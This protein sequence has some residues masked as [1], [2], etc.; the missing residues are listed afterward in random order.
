MF[1]RKKRRGSENDS[2]LGGSKKRSNNKKSSDPTEVHRMQRN[3]QG[4]IS[5]PPIPIDTLSRHV[6]QLKANGGVKFLQEFEVCLI[7]V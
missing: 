7:A 6:D 5:H 4:M 2:L 1:S 3:T